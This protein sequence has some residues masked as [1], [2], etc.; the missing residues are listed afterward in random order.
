MNF[1]GFIM[2]CTKTSLQSFTKNDINRS[3]NKF[4]YVKVLFTCI[5]TIFLCMKNNNE[6]A[7]KSLH[8][9]PNAVNC[10][11]AK[12]WTYGF[13]CGILVS[14]YCDVTIAQLFDWLIDFDVIMKNLPSA[15][16]GIRRSGN[17]AKRPLS[18]DPGKRLCCPKIN[19]NLAAARFLLWSPR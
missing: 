10:P 8:G 3:L 4:V 7:S 12:F 15:M 14:F 2:W 13:P 16:S 1:Q 9:K 17:F 5:Y 6:I 18:C 11:F 19:K